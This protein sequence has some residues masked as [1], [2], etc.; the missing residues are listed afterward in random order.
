MIE[1]G[2]YSLMAGLSTGETIVEGEW[3]YK[4]RPQII[5]A[6]KE[7]RDMKQTVADIEGTIAEVYDISHPDGYEM[8]DITKAYDEALK[9]MEVAASEI[10][11]IKCEDAYGEVSE[12]I[13]R[14]AADAGTAWVNFVDLMA[15]TN[16]WSR[17][18]SNR[19]DRM[20]IAASKIHFA[21]NR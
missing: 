4:V 12:R 15:H 6:H 13:T 9:H 16:R 1:N 2:A 20:A 17:C 8:G 10:Y 5:A 19:M 11:R 14:H 3:V 18:F 21:V 7:L